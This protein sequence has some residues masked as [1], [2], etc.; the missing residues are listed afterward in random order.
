IGRSLTSVRLRL[1]A[2][3]TWS[4]PS[5]KRSAQ[6]WRLTARSVSLTALPSPRPMPPPSGPMANSPP[7]S[8]PSTTTT[9][10]SAL[11]PGYQLSP[12]IGGVLP[13]EHE[14]ADGHARGTDGGV[15]LAQEELV[16]ALADAH[17]VVAQ[18][19]RRVEHGVSA[20]AVVEQHRVEVRVVARGRVD[21]AHAIEAEPSGVDRILVRPGGAEAVLAHGDVVAPRR[22]RVVLEEALDE[23]LDAEERDQRRPGVGAAELPADQGVEVRRIAAAAQ[24]LQLARGQGGDAKVLVGGESLSSHCRDASS[25]RLG[26]PSRSAAPRSQ[27]ARPSPTLVGLA[28]FLE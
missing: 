4:A 19:A 7:T 18:R 20:A 12:P 3:S 9:R 23:L 1:P 8:A 16:R 28:A 14:V 25:L 24:P 13:L 17:Q 5:T 15:G 21:A 26:A 6:C 2:S 10:G 22:A 11:R 27:V